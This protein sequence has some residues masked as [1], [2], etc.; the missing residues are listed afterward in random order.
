MLTERLQYRVHCSLICLYNILQ[1]SF[2]ILGF[3]LANFLISNK[4]VFDL[5]AYLS[6]ICVCTH[7]SFLKMQWDGLN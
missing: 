1:H 4:Y 5:V 7:S 2:S 6:F 3:L